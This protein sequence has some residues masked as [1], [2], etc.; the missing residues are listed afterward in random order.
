MHGHNLKRKD[1]FREYLLPTQI[2]K[3]NPCKLYV[4]H[5]DDT[6]LLNVKCGDVIRTGEFNIYLLKITDKKTLSN[7]FYFIASHQHIIKIILPTR[8]SQHTAAL[9]N[10]YYCKSSRKNGKCIFWYLGDTIV[11]QFSLLNFLGNHT[12][13][14]IE[15]G[16]KWFTNE[17]KL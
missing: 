15:I 9:I 2:L 13:K 12:V 7:F 3:W 14:Y 4:W 17:L 6:K 8:I 11:R 10:T 16:N 5:W 1:I